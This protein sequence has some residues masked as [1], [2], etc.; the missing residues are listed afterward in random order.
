MNAYPN[1]NTQY[2]ENGHLCQKHQICCSDTN[3]NSEH[4]RTNN[5][6]FLGKTSPLMQHRRTAHQSHELIVKQL[7]SLLEWL[8]KYNTGFGSK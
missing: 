7:I 2:Y 3:L 5:N 6:G 8:T 1:A 4:F